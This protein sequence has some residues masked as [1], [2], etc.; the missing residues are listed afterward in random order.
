[1]LNEEPDSM[2]GPP[3]FRISSGQVVALILAVVLV[4]FIVTN[5]SKTTATLLF[6]DVTMRLWLLMTLTALLGFGLGFLV[7]RRRRE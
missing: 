1:M 7:G 4:A 6:F 3:R 2:H 5:N